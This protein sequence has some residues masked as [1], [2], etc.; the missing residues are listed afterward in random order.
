[1]PL[2]SKTIGKF[3]C[4][5]IFVASFAQAVRDPFLFIALPASPPI[6]P[7]PAEPKKEKTPPILWAARGISSGKPAPYVLLG[8]NKD[9]VIVR[10]GEDLELGWHVEKIM[11]NS[12]CLKHTT[13]SVKELTV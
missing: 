13:G 5:A 6:A 7:K 8:K 4:V 12:V 2:K 3:W 1:M 11:R 9:I 10:E